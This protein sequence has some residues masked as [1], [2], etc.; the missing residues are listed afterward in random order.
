MSNALAIYEECQKTA[1]QLRMFTGDERAKL[2]E[3]LEDY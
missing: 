2:N 3:L 1:A